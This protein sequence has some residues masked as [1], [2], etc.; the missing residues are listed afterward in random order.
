[1]RIAAIT[2]AGALAVSTTAFAQST[3]TSTASSGAEYTTEQL[4]TELNLTAAQVPKVQKINEASA[5]SLQKL[6]DKYDADTSAAAEA[7][8][9][10]GIVAS[11]RSN[12]TE[13]KKVLT[14]TQWAIHQKN[15]AQRVAQ[16]QT[17]FMASDLNLTR[18]QILDV[19]RINAASADQ[20]V[21]AL[22]KPMGTG[23]PTH[24]ALYTAAKPVLDARDAELHRVL[25]VD[26]WKQ[27]EVRRRALV[28]V[29]VQEASAK[30][31]TSTAAGKKKKS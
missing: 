4:K 11:I 15:K 6:L 1:M 9:A 17:E 24:Q 16:S 26:Q 13:L 3:A 5:Q 8:L 14:P 28:D 20:L 7:A 2:M 31:T 12:Q 23:K 25:T 19:A 30:P 29:F 21:A 10:R 22:D 18:Q 27:M